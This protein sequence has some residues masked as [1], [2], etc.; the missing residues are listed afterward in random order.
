[1]KR[2]P[3]YTNYEIE[4][5]GHL[6]NPLSGNKKMKALVGKDILVSNKN[7]VVLWL[8][9]DAELSELEELDEGLLLTIIKEAV[10]Q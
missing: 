3:E 8:I 7:K 9:Q 10:A 2:M 1:M 4:K 5:N 6:K